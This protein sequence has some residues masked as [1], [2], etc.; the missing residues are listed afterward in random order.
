MET[1]ECMFSENICEECRFPGGPKHYED[2]VQYHR[3][4]EDDARDHDSDPLEE[5]LALMAFL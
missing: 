4:L 5:D 3:F 1:Y 2:C